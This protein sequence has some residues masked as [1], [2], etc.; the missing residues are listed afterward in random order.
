MSPEL[1]SCHIFG[2]GLIC[3]YDEMGVVIHQLGLIL[4]LILPKAKETVFK[5][6]I[7]WCFCNLHLKHKGNKG[8]R[9]LQ[10]SNKLHPSGYMFTVEPEI[11]KAVWRA[12]ASN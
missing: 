7:R 6:S 4:G 5:I 10:T 8:F 11:L 3:V 1:Q 12:K 2:I 9:A